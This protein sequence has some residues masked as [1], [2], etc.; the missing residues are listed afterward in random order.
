MPNIQQM[1]E[2]PKRVVWKE[3][4]RTWFGLPWTFTKYS[5]TAE[6]FILERGLLHHHVDEVR[7]YRIKDLSLRRSFTERLLGLGTISVISADR[8][9]PRFEIARIKNS[10][11]VKELLSDLVEENRRRN[12]VLA[13]EIFGK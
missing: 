12:R 10:R 13:G 2:Q 7:L 1:M 11:A 6:K 4:R 5:L 9:M 8:S 3:R